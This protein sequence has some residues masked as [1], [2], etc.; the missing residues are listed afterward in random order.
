MKYDISN[1]FAPPFTK[2]IISFFIFYLPTLYNWIHDLTFGFLL[3]LS[4]INVVTK[5][6][7][8]SANMLGLSFEG[9]RNEINDK[10]WTHK[11]IHST[12]QPIR[13][14]WAHP[15]H[16]RMHGPMLNKLLLARKL[17]VYFPSCCRNCSGTFKRT[18]NEMVFIFCGLLR[19]KIKQHR[20]YTG[21]S[22]EVFQSHVNSFCSISH[23]GWLNFINPDPAVWRWKQA[24]A[25]NNAAYQFIVLLLGATS[26]LTASSVRQQHNQHNKKS[27][28]FSCFSPWTKPFDSLQVHLFRKNSQRIREMRIY[29]ITLKSFCGPQNASEMILKWKNSQEIREMRIYM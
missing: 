11:N 13:R 25:G 28:F 20:H 12:I 3:L 8:L 24:G 1:L 27:K 14:I 29:F 6:L 2:Y 7:C 19:F 5:I 16:R 9:K 23:H 26:I 4:E 15:L 21:I 17:S 22:V 10:N 18:K